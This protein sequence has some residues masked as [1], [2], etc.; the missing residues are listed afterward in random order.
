MLEQIGAS[1]ALRREQTYL[2]LKI[3]NEKNIIYFIK[4]R[5]AEP[6]K[7]AGNML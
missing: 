3:S 6:K 7:V 4:S 1:G 5:C 2:Q